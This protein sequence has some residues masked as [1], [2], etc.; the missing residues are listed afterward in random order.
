MAGKSLAEIEASLAAED[1]LAARRGA[2]EAE[3]L[4]R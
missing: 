3:Q 1:Q 4:E 2:H